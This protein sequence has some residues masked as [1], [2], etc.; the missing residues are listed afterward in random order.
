MRKAVILQSLGQRADAQRGDRAPFCI[1]DRNADPRHSR[2]E[3]RVDVGPS[4]PPHIV[5]LHAQTDLVDK[6][7][8]Q[9][10]RNIEADDRFALAVRKER[11]HGEASL[12]DPQRHLAA[13]IAGKRSDRERALDAIETY[14]VEA[15]PHEQEDGVAQCCR[16]TQKRRAGKIAKTVGLAR[17]GRQ[18][19][20]R[21]SETVFSAAGPLL[22]ESF[23]D[24]RLQR[25]MGAGLI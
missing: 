20:K 1:E 23:G 9:Q 6:A 13:N 8:V 7:S 15:V 2:D 4:E 21:Q 3:P 17:A 24:Q 22:D 19:E 16:K 12:A 10:P 14:G 25:P 18:H 5:D 11:Q